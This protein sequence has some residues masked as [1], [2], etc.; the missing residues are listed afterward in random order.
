MKLNKDHFSAHSIVI[1]ISLLLIPF[2]NFHQLPSKPLNQEFVIQNTGPTGTGSSN[3]TILNTTYLNGTRAYNS[4]N[5]GCSTTTQCGSI[6][7]KGNL[8]LI[9]NKLVISNGGSITASNSPSST[10]GTGTS[11]QLS[12]SWQ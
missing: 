2:T 3:A 10:Q 5:I 4:L 6:I 1:V 8:I 11:V 7:A 12:S 9:V